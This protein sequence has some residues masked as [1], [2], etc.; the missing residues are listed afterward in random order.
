LTLVKRLR[1]AFA[2]LTILPV[3]AVETDDGLQRSAAFFPV[4]GFFVGAVSFV[5]IELASVRLGQEAAAALVVLWML[6]VTGGFHLD[7]LADSVDGI[8]G[9]RTRG[10]RLKIM[11]SGSSGPIGVAAVTVLLL[12]KFGLLSGTDYERLWAALL[13][14]PALARWSIV[15]MAW[16]SPPVRRDG[17][18]HV[19]AGR[20]RGVDL[21]AATG[22]VALPVLALSY[23]WGYTYLAP[24]TTA[25]LV[26]WGAM[27]LFRRL[28]GGVTGDTLGATVEVGEVAILT[29]FFLVT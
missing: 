26:S 11:R 23:L 17:L 27:A 16:G 2:F 29:V 13:L 10:A 28:L 21:L 1:A 19:F 25:I 18:G 7:G 4:V 8:A 6:L 15:M 9:G 14:T 5:I 3:G 20:I 24:A 12:L 22:F